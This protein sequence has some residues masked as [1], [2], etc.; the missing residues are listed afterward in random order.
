MDKNTRIVVS[1]L[2]A[3]IAAVISGLSAY[4]IPHIARVWQISAVLSIVALLTYVVSDIYFFKA[5]FAKK[6]ARY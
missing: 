2:T 4:L 3:V 5:L 1:G 6:T